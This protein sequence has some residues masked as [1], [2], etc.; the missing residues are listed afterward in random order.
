MVRGVLP[1]CCLPVPF[2]DTVGNDLFRLINMM[3]RQYV[4]RHQSTGTGL[5]CH[6][7]TSLLEVRI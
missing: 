1:E 3:L 7:V 6:T 2:L 5:L 4:E